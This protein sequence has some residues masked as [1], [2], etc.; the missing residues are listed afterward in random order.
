MDAEEGDEDLEESFLS[1]FNKSIEV[2]SLLRSRSRGS[3]F[4]DDEQMEFGSSRRVHRLIQKAENEEGPTLP[5]LTSV[6]SYFEYQRDKGFRFSS[7]SETLFNAANSLVGIGLL[8]L[9]Y[10]LHLCGWF[11]IVILFFFAALTCYTAKLL[12]RIMEVTPR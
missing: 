1:T 4:S 7:F 11:G 8:S 5:E 3:L 10:A 9:P 6:D 12:G 2:T